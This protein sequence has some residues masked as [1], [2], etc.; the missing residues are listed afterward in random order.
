MIV[1]VGGISLRGRD[2]LLQPPARRRPADRY[3][4]RSCFGGLRTQPEETSVPEGPDSVVDTVT[5]DPYR[6]VPRPR[7]VRAAARGHA[8]LANASCTSFDPLR[9]AAG[10]LAV[11]AARTT[12]EAGTRSASQ[13]AGRGRRAGRGGPCSIQ[14]RSRPRRASTT[15]K[16][17]L[18]GPRVDGRAG[19]RHRG[20]AYQPA[21]CAFDPF[22]TGSSAART[23]PRATAEPR[24]RRSSMTAA[25]GGSSAGFTRGEGTR[26]QVSASTPS[27]ACSTRARRGFV[28]VAK[29]SAWRASTSTRSRPLPASRRGMTSAAATR[30]GDVARRSSDR[31]RSEPGPRRAQSS[32]VSDRR[33]ASSGRRMLPRRGAIPASPAPP[34]R[35]ASAAGRSRPDRRA[36]VDEDRF[37]RDFDAHLPPARRARVARPR[38][39]VRTETHLD[40]HDPHRRAERSAARRTVSASCPV[41]ERR[42]WSTYTACTSSRVHHTNSSNANESAR[43]C[44]DDHTAP[45]A[46]SR[47]RRGVHTRAE[48]TRASQCAGSFNSA[49]VG[50]SRAAT[51]HRV[52]C[53][54]TADVVDARTKSSPTWY[55]FI[56]CRC[57]QLVHGARDPADL[58]RCESTPTCVPDRRRAHDRDRHHDVA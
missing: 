1:V 54:A 16:L 22:A 5:D 12:T 25:R 23:S 28:V 36:C 7:R 29:D 49:T 17:Q 24:G 55:C 20:D 21:A 13:T 2:A 33:E 41:P 37:R 34:R 56:F 43:R 26:E 4:G 39:E 32:C 31:A 10:T 35:A 45:G 52:E 38:F 40:A 42:P 19:R 3:S 30:A 18:D 46:R 27:G 57:E 48:S 51:P 53:R 58:R 9:R 14:A 44:T 8:R 15:G 50:N 11:V 6:L 47:A